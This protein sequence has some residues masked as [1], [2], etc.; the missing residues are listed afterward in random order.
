MVLKSTPLDSLVCLKVSLDSLVCLKVSLDS[1]VCLKVSLD[2]LV[3][4][5]MPQFFTITHA[6]VKQHDQPNLGQIIFSVALASYGCCFSFL[7]ERV[8]FHVGS[9]SV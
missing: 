7:G 2:S 5:S 3:C 9:S 1:L 8:C 6:V 4:L